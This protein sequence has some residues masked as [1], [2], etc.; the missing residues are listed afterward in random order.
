MNRRDFLDWLYEYCKGGQVETRALPARKQAF[1]DRGDWNS[2]D[3]FCKT[4]SRQNLYFAVATR[5]GGGGKEFIA[6]IP[7]VW[8]DIDFKDYPDIATAKKAV[9]GFPLRP[10]VMLETGGG[11]HALWRLKEPAGKDEISDIEKIL[12]GIAHHLGADQQ[13]TDASRIL[14]L[15]ETANH[16]YEHKPAVK[17][18]WDNRQLEYNPAD[19]DDH[20]SLYKLEIVSDYPLY[21]PAIDSKKAGLARDIAGQSVTYLTL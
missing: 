8:A 20:L 5:N 9:F 7:G 13:A 15:P 16:K 21:H 18:V 1:H 19:F 10:S 6:E 11:Y 2:V 3:K 4:H 12:K 14:R 17:V